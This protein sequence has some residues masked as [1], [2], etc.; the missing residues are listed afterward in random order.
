MCTGHFAECDTRPRGALPSV[1]VITLDKVPIP[2]HRYS[3]F[4]ECR[5][6]DTRQRDTLCRVPQRA[7]DKEADKGTHWRIICRVI[8]GRHSAKK[9][10]L[11]RVSPNTLGKGA[12]SVTLAPWRRLFFAEYCLALDKV[13]A[14]CPKKYS[15]K[16]ALPMYC[17]SSPLCWVRHS[18]KLVPSVFQALPSASGTRQRGQ[19]R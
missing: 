5:G 12:V 13:Y 1:R 18:A 9:V 14:E 15:A 10:P 11:C 6:P 2:E 4:V 16:K 17:S 8:V 19:F 3:F 7:L